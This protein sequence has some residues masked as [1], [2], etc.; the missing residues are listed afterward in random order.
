MS[1]AVG[2]RTSRRRSTRRTEEGWRERA[3]QVVRVRRILWSVFA[4]ANF[5]LLGALFIA[6]SAVYLDPRPFW[7]AQIIAVLLPF[8][9]GL[10][11]LTTLVVLWRRRWLLFAIHIAILVWAGVRLGPWD[12]MQDSL[13]ASPT[14]LAI[15]SYN[16]P[17][18]GYDREGYMDAVEAFLRE[19]N[20]DVIALQKAQSAPPHGG[21]PGYRA[22]QARIA[23]ERLGYRF[24][25]P[26]T[27]VRRPGTNPAARPAL[28]LG[29]LV[30]RQTR[31]GD[32]F[33][34]D[35]EQIQFSA[36]DTTPSEATRVQFRWQGR[37]GV[38]YM[39][40]LRSYGQDK[41]WD[42]DTSE[43]RRRGFYE[44][45]LRQYRDAH[46][47]RARDVDELRAR[48]DAEILPVIIIGDFNSTPNQR[49]YRVLAGDRQ[50]AFRAAGVGHGGTWRSDYPFVRIDHII[51][52]TSFVVTHAHVPDARLSDHRPIIAR[53][54]WRNDRSVDTSTE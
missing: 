41:P 32:F 54:R 12:R 21:R 2:K 30:R 29:L 53:I 43:L 10:T 23:V 48:I 28:G 33:V 24:F 4:V 47:R 16:L 15:M 42:E 25:I 31:G 5:A 14:D 19:Q 1:T 34:L 35:Q 45:Y 40:H 8:L 46:R 36:G 39:V 49:D 13:E 9:A 38:M 52:D 51:A 18:R 50:D 37:Q 44:T 27:V 11:A 6:M 26:A 7:W 22:L 3:R 17:L 20:A